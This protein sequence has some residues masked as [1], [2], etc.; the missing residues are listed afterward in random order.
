MY[1]LM[2]PNY[3]YLLAGDALTRTLNQSGRYGS[4]CLHCTVQSLKYAPVASIIG[5]S[6]PG[7]LIG[8][9]SVTFGGAP[10]SECTTTAWMVPIWDRSFSLMSVCLLGGRGGVEVTEESL[11]DH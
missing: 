8:H 7:S 4:D 2:I 10:N 6:I 3:C 9:L 11:C 1:N 5:L